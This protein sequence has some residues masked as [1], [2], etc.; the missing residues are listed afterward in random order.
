MARS[1]SRAAPSRRG[2]GNGDGSGVGIADGI[3]DWIGKGS[4]TRLPSLGTSGLRRERI[5]EGMASGA[6]GRTDGRL[7]TSS[8]LGKT[9]SGAPLLGLAPS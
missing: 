3:G 7:F 5:V 9:P 6:R 8:R 2:D 1:R 4:P